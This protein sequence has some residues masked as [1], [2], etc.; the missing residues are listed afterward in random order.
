MAGSCN[1]SRSLTPC[2]SLR[3]GQINSM[4]LAFIGSAIVLA[5]LIVPLAWDPASW[6]GGKKQAVSSTARR[7]QAA[8]GGRR[9]RYER[10][11]QRVTL[12]YGGSQTLL[13]QAELGEQGDLYIPPTA[14]REHRSRSPSHRRVLPLARMIP[15]L[16]VARESA[17][18]PLAG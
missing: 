17:Q 18:R 5:M 11:R 4:W 7:A 13:A 14:A 2:V 9:P 1:T 16:V 3:P 8:R 15:L 12:Q 10:N 6:F